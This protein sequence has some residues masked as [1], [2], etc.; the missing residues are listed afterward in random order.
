MAAQSAIMNAAQLAIDD[1][2]RPENA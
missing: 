2:A 1:V